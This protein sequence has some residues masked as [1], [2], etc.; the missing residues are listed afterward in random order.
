M[1]RKLLD[2]SRLYPTDIY[3]SYQSRALTWLVECL[4]SVQ[5]VLGLTPAPHIPDVVGHACNPST[6]A[7]ETVSSWDQPG[8]QEAL[9]QNKMLDILFYLENKNKSNPTTWYSLYLSVFIHFVHEDF[10]QTFHF[11]MLW[12]SFSILSGQNYCT[13]PSYFNYFMNTPTFQRSVLCVRALTFCPVIRILDCD[14]NIWS[15]NDLGQVSF[16][17]CCSTIMKRFGGKLR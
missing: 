5:E 7:V 9:L 17:F 15:L 6:Q 10:T 3:S 16:S 14:S 2:G 12:I 8:I 13:M 11:I 4:P 1:P